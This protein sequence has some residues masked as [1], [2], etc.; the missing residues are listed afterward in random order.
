MLI[1]NWLFVIC[2][3]RQSAVC[4]SNDL[5][6]CMPLMTLVW[7][8]HVVF[9]L[10][11]QSLKVSGILYFSN[12]FFTLVELVQCSY[13]TIHFEK[14]THFKK[15]FS[16]CVKFGTSLT[17]FEKKIQS[18]LSWSQIKRTL[19]K[20]FRVRN[21]VKVGCYIALVSVH[22]H[23]IGIVSIFSAWTFKDTLARNSATTFEMTSSPHKIGTEYW[24]KTHM[25]CVDKAE[26]FWSALHCDL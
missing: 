23:S 17:H 10:C 6:L 26:A 18:A 25:L 3:V 7:P 1:A 5:D 12:F 20:N 8:W 13:V 11:H 22:Y 4:H 21:F 2:R 15:Q 14:I 19:K 24:T 9:S 16:K